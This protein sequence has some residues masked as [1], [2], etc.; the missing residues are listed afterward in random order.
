MQRRASK[1]QAGLGRV[2]GKAWDDGIDHCRHAGSVGRL[3]GAFQKMNYLLPTSQT[4][5]LACIWRWAT[6]A[7]EVTRQ[8]VTHSSD[9]FGRAHTYTPTTWPPYNR[10]ADAAETHSAIRDRNLVPTYN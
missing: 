5:H 3:S 7:G 9:R 10:L 4:S 2:A 6:A 8:A 1:C